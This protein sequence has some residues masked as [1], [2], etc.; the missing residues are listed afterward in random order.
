[1]KEKL[2]QFRG[3]GN[4]L[5]DLGFDKAEAKNR[6]GLNVRLVIAHRRQP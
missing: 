5:L 3:R 1:M 6:A 4:V 2:K